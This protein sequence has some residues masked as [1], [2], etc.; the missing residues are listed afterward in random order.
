MC[1][2][3]RLAHF[4]KNASA[5]AGANT[6]C[7]ALAAICLVGLSLHC[8]LSCGCIKPIP[9]SSHPCVWF[10]RAT[11]IW[12]M[13]V[14]VWVCVRARHAYP[15]WLRLKGYSIAWETVE[16]ACRGSA[17][18][19]H[20]DVSH[21]S[22]EWPGE[23]G[24]RVLADTLRHNNTLTSLDLTWNRL[25]AGGGRAL[26][27]TLPQQHPMSLDLVYSAPQNP[28]KIVD[29]AA[30][31]KIRKY[32]DASHSFRRQPFLGLPACLHAY[33][34]PHPRGVLEPAAHAGS[35]GTSMH[36]CT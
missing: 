4:Y 28:Y 3:S 21:P 24:G 31:E 6:R 20:P 36:H 5:L 2:S 7:Y 9:F 18:Q 34:G 14:C 23:G 10:A 29:D 12:C 19:Q 26:A 22:R 35:A 33:I 25:G 11:S 17:P 16:G 15:Y 32:R 13:C 1:A 8:T 27:E 30:A